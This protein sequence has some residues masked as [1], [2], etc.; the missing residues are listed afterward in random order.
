MARVDQIPSEQPGPASELDDEA[1]SLADGLEQP[2]DARGAVVGAK[3]EAELVHHGEIRPVVR[4]LHGCIFTHRETPFGRRRGHDS[5]AHP[6]GS[7]D[8]APR[9]H[10]GSVIRVTRV[11]CRNGR[12]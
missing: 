3:P 4:G 6:M 5:A 8:S 11:P 12:A 7:F 10:T 2:K 1:G 9:H